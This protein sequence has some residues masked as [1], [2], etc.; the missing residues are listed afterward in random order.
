[1]SR[2]SYTFHSKGK[3]GEV[4]VTVAAVVD[5]KQMKF[6]VSRCSELDQF[7][8][9]TGTERA[10]K[11]AMEKSIMITPVPKVKEVSWFLGI[12]KTIAEQAKLNSQLV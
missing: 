5:G 10:L 12:A 3:Q 8:K 6:G 11:R 4:R 1:M 9:K 7:V 2:L